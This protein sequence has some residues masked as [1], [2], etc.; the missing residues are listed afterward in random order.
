MA[1]ARN[2]HVST[3]RLDEYTINALLARNHVGSIALAFHDRVTIALANYVYAN[4]H[5]YGRLE[6]GPDLTT[7]RHH[8][9]VAFQ[10]S[11]IA[12]TYEWRTVIARGSIE[13]LTDG[14]SAA[15]SAA[16][17]E[18]LDLIRGIAPAVFTPRDPMPRRVHLFRI[19]VDDLTGHEARSE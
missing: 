16:F 13:V 1:T 7:V 12:G 2:V 18:A 17:R 10:V 8:Q 5:I 9:W 15:A 3:R 6:E 11:E 4:G 19:Y 14:P